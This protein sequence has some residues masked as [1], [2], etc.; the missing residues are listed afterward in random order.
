MEGGK[1]TLKAH[2]PDDDL[3][4]RDRGMFRYTAFQ[5][6]ASHWQRAP[7]STGS[8]IRAI[9]K[10]SAA[11]WTALS[12]YTAFSEIGLYGRGRGWDAAIT[13]DHWQLADYTLSE[14]DLPYDRLP[15]A[16]LSVDRPLVGLLHQGVNAETVRFQHETEPAGSRVD[17]KPWLSLPCAAMPGS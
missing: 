7:T 12:Q 16:Y 13:A 2:M 1:G 6:V 15:R 10:T 14:S 4:G 3:R 11:A 5:N 17:L 8:A 9:S